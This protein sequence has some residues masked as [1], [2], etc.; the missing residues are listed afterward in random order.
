MR[1]LGLAT[2]VLAAVAALVAPTASPGVA[3][4]DRQSAMPTLT[5]TRQV[6]G[7][8]IPWDVQPL[9]G[10]RLLIDE[11]AN[12]RLI[13][14]HNGVKKVLTGFA[15][16]KVWSSGETGVMGLEVDPAFAK[17]RRIYTCQGG[18]TAGGGHDVRVVAWRLNAAY[19]GVR[20]VRTLV[21]G[22]PATSG[23]HGGCRLLIT[24]N[25]ALIVGTGDAATTANP[26]NLRSFGGKTLRL[27]RMTGAPWPTNKWPK[28]KSKVRR[29]VLTYGHR[30]VQ[31]LA[32][33]ADGT[34]WSIEQGTYRDDEVNRLV[35]GGNF[36]WR[37]GPGY[38]EA[39]PMTN[40]A[41]P[42]V[43]YGARW[44]SGDP[45]LATSGGTFVRG[46]QWGDL[47][48]TLA[49]AALRTNQVLFLRF[50]KAGKLLWTRAPAALKSFGR[51]RSISVAPN[52]DLLVT[53]SNGSNDAVL[54]VRPRLS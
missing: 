15:A 24:R 9:P 28:A 22:F 45:T 44:R 12:R 20:Y 40:H 5:V 10:G 21:K 53:T 6:T 30:N 1:R 36:G 32:Q 33:R 43:Q 46:A 42:G 26:Q 49:V 23:R 19:T 31:G 47:N 7:L 27:N 3:A 4:P 35:N 29:Y 50:D 38:D 48:G 16:S 11:R 39:P 25:G 51:L 41:L 14:W 8:S 13:V 54:R 17:N 52:G 18:F 37:P 2:V 34:L